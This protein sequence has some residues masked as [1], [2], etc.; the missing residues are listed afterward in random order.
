MRIFDELTRTTN[1]TYTFTGG[2]KTFLIYAF[3]REGVDFLTILDKINILAIK[4]SANEFWGKRSCHAKDSNLCK[5][6]YVFKAIDI[7]FQ[8]SFNFAT[9]SGTNS[10]SSG[11]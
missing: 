4:H 2:D 5:A 6:I 7:E 3:C 9:I 11:Q 10:M 8:L 1:I